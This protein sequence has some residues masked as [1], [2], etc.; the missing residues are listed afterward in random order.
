MGSDSTAAEEGNS[1]DIVA[2]V[3]TVESAGTAWS[4]GSVQ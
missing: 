4:V 1:M 3:K 2:G